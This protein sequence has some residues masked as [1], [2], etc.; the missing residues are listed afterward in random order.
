M[1]DELTGDQVQELCRVVSDAFDQI[2]QDIHERNGRK[3]KVS[4]LMQAALNEMRELE[5]DDKGG[6]IADSIS[7]IEKVVAYWEYWVIRDCC[8]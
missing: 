4:E 5:I 3:A 8:N 2:M 1:S 7:E 6:R